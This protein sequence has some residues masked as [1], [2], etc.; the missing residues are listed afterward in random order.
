MVNHPNRS[1]R[2]MV[3]VADFLEIYDAAHAVVDRIHLHV[4]HAEYQGSVNA[5]Q[6]FREI[7]SKLRRRHDDK[8][9][10]PLNSTG[11]DR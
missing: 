11:L 6:D 5:V 7:A 3:P 10:D 1:K 4:D 9:R 2:R 8:I